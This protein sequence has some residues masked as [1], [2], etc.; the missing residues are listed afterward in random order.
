MHIRRLPPAPRTLI[1]GLVLLAG[2][3][4]FAGPAGAAPDPP[5]DGLLQYDR[6][7]IERL[8]PVDYPTIQSAI[9]A[10]KPL[11]TISVGPGLYEEA[12]EVRNLNGLVIQGSGAGE[13]IVRS[14]DTVLRIE[15]TSSVHVE[16]IRFESSAEVVIRG[17]GAGI[18]FVRNV[19]VASAEHGRLEFSCIRGG[20]DFTKSTFVRPGGSGPF[21]V[22]NPEPC[23]GS[24][25]VTVYR[26]LFWTWGSPVVDGTGGRA[27]IHQNNLG[28]V[29]QWQYP[30]DNLFLFPLFCDPDSGDYTLSS[31]SPC[32]PDNNPWNTTIGAL[33]QACGPI[34][35]ES[36]SWGQLKSGYR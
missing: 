35:V 18:R 14:P 10:A 30:E 15:D 5:T 7:P 13:T 23:G 32:M 6:D 29:D 19:V 36:V 9:D 34:S 2:L 16:G 20:S 11:D 24:G 17:V 27:L 8:V 28:M 22:L 25:L 21:L 12:L 26:S 4:G 3:A 1:P 33:G 31:G